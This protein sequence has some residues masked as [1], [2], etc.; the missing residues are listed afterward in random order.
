MKL[1][2]IEALLYG[3]KTLCGDIKLSSYNLDSF[4]RPLFLLFLLFLGTPWPLMPFSVRARKIA[5]VPIWEFRY[6][7]SLSIPMGSF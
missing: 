5:R 4:H 7:A 6:Y 2:G 3:F 1:S